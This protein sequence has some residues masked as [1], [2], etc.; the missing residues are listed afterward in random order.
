MKMKKATVKSL[1]LDKVN[2]APV[3][4]LSIEDENR[5]IPIWIGISEAN[6]I[7][8]KL[9]GMTFPR[10]LT[11]DLIINILNALSYKIERLTIHSIVNNTFMASIWIKDVSETE[12]DNLIEIDARPSDC[13]ILS[14]SNN[15]PLY[16]SNEIIEKHSIVIETS[17]KEDE[18]FKNFVDNMDLET[19][20]RFFNESGDKNSEA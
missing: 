4:L 3:V 13:I 10:P 19:F 2:N 20:R 16:I 1:M 14:I 9:E 18:T 11:H 8:L 7:A 6:L 5:V 17:D 12:D 15:I